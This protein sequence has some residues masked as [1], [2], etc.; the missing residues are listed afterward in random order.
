MEQTPENQPAQ[1]TT[2]TTHTHHPCSGRTCSSGKGKFF[3]KFLLIVLGIS[4]YLNFSLFIAVKS[5]T[6]GGI[7]QT[8]YKEGQHRNNI[9]IIPIKGVINAKQENFVKM[10]F[11]SLEKNAQQMPK[12][13]VL[14]VD[15]PGGDP[16]ASDHIWQTISKFKKKHP[17]IPIIGSV[18]ALCASG[19][20]Y[21]IAAVDH[22]YAEPIS[23]VGSVGVISINFT[24]DK[25]M[26]KIGIAPSVMIATKSPKK[27]I[28]NNPFRWE[29]KDK[30]KQLQIMDYLQEQFVHVV[31]SERHR[32]LTAAGDK[33]VTLQSIANAC[34]GSLYRVEDAIR[35]KFVDSKGYL[36]DAI[37]FAAKKANMTDKPHVTVLS[38][39]SSNSLISSLLGFS[40]ENSNPLAGCA[41]TPKN[42][43]KNL[44]TQN[45]RDAMIELSTPKLEFRYYPQNAR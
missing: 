25:L 7:V 14:R 27:D 10:A 9:V 23:L 15:S 31:S 20:Y 12:A 30:Q 16:W 37:A 22:I 11:E 41:S 18:G 36:D 17:D 38:L 42:L 28:A 4:I 33:T 29:D 3:R 26:D 19:G 5:L 8:V 43:L 2:T 39:K 1:I 13:I 34:D 45:L 21:S 32:A 24:M 35:V 40:T 44:N 6:G